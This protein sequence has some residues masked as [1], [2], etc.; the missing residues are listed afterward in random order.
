MDVGTA[1]GRD[2]SGVS[3]G[4]GLGDVAVASGVG[5]GASVAEAGATLA[6]ADAGA[7]GDWAPG[8]LLHPVTITTARAGASQRRRDCPARAAPPTAAAR[9]DE[10]WMI[11]FIVVPL[12][13]LIVRARAS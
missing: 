4:D 7:L 13:T 11:A 2:A 9:P 8:E 1:V 3:A 10:R 5:D 12:V 6:G